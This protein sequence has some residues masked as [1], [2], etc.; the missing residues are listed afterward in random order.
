MMK[1]RVIDKK[2]DR[3]EVIECDQSL[4]NWYETKIKLRDRNLAD[5]DYH[6]SVNGSGFAI[7]LNPDHHAGEQYK[8][9]AKWVDKRSRHSGKSLCV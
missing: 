2:T 6:L 1:L 3:I 7:N 8:R 5:Y 4:K 9:L